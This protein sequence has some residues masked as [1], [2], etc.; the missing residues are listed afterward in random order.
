MVSSI[1]L[2]SFIMGITP[3]ITRKNLNFGVM[4]PERAN[5]LPEVQSWKKSFR[6]WSMALGA[7]GVLPLFGGFLLNLDEASLVNYMVIVGAITLVAI[8]FAQ[9][10]LYFHFH[11][12]AKALK[13]E[14]FSAEEIKAD[15]RIMVSTNFRNEKVIISNKWLIIVGGLIIAVTA[16][17]PII[18]YDQI[19]EHVPVN[20]NSTTATNFRSRSRQLFLLVPA[21]QLGVLALFIFANYSFK[22][23]KQ[24]LVPRNAKASTQQNRAYRYAMSKMIIATGIGTMLIISGLQMTMMLATYDLPSFMIWVPILFS[25]LIIISLIYISFKYG[26]G[27][28]RYNPP[29]A[30]DNDHNIIDDDAHWKWGMIYYNPNDPAVFVEKR[31]GI[32]TTFNFARW[33]AWAMIFGILVFVIITMIIA[34][35]MVDS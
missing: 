27:G 4:L 29:Q 33:Q 12:K 25:G 30:A 35:S 18:F 11:N 13:A 9:V 21:L 3:Y 10:V 23:T 32:G 7:I 28:E 5:L 8:A 14:R 20:W 16:L 26:Q 22:A 17:L 2:V 15:A 34:F 24:M 1:I 31:F 19:P 6:G